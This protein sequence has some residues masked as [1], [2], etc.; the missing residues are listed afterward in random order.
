MA[1][2]L[3]IDGGG[4][5]CR[6]ALADGSGRILGT[7]MAGPANV[8]TD[9][10]ATRDNI[11]AATE[12]ARRTAGLDSAPHDMVAVLG[13]AGANVTAAARALADSLPFARLRIVTDA[14]T[15]T[16]GAL[17]DGD[18]I[19]AAIG[20]GSVLTTCRAGH[21]QQFGGRGF[22]L[23]D[24]GSG[25]VLGRTLLARALRAEDGFVPMTPLLAEL[26]V[27]LGG[28]EGVI[29][30][31]KDARPA[32]FAEFAPRITGSD[33]PAALT[34]FDSA[35]E[36][37]AGMID[38]LQRQGPLPV[39]FLGGL[40]TRY[41]ARLAGRWPVQM[42]QGNGLDGALRLAIELGRTEERA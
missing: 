20:T 19:V 34:I 2:F 28:I 8:N 27:E 23:G 15:A 35:A 13:L 1:I 17:G 21:V 31:A 32:Q 40:G 29:R 6:A 18:G 25:A 10:A 7:G 33:D 16:K 36:E 12:Q 4:T 30:F 11:L 42:P 9:L 41:G 38:H 37:L 22:L 3:G 5:G 24:E 26:L 14:I 39:V